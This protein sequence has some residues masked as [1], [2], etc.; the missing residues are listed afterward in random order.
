MKTSLRGLM[1]GICL[2]GGALSAP[3]PRPAPPR[4]TATAVAEQSALTRGRAL[5]RDF[6]AVRLLGLWGAFSA[7]VRRQWGSLEA[8][9]AFREQGV[10]QYGAEEQVV[11]ERTFTRDGE[12]FYVRSA[13]FEGA[14][15]L[16]WALVV[17]FKGSRVTTFGIA[18][19][20]DR[21]DGPVGGARGVGPG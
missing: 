20:E 3:P 12:V 16:V 7:D 17:G 13:T 5:L 14:P 2:L 4:P 15:G 9:Q 8:F 11:Q 21:R 6:Y 19:Q 1:L 18:L 10:R